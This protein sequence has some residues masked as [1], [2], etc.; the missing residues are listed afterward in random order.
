M[1]PGSSLS[2]TCMFVNKYVGQKESAA[3]PA[4]KRSAGVPLEVN[5]KN[6]LPTG[7]EAHK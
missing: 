4:L 3:I 7:E 5:L 1:I 6:T 2:N